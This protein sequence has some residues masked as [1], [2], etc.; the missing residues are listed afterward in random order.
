LTQTPQGFLAISALLGAIGSFFSGS[1]T[2]SNLTFG[3]IQEVRR[4]TGWS[5]SQEGIYSY[6][7]VTLCGWLLQRAAS[8]C[9]LQAFEFRLQ[10]L[11]ETLVRISVKQSELF[12]VWLEPSETPAAHLC[13]AAQVA[14]ERLGM[15]VT[16]FLAV[17]AAG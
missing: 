2:V 4:P 17:Q 15:S 10:C 5:A 6:A 12:F 9:S 16:A 11:L 13:C 14:A 1:T 3:E 8:V 7:D